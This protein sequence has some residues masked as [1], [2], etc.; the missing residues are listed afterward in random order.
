MHLLSKGGQSNAALQWIV[1]DFISPRQWCAILMLK[2]IGIFSQYRYDLNK[3]SDCHTMFDW[4]EGRSY[5]SRRFNTPNSWRHFFEYFSEQW[6]TSDEFIEP[7]NRFDNDMSRTTNKCEGLHFDF[8]A[9]LPEP[10]PIGANF[11]QWAAIGKQIESI[12]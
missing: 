8:R 12:L 11:I 3:Y 5:R 6:M 7:W 9:S 1:V 10:H 4:Y 2:S